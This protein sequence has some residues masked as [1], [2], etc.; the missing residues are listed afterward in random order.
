ME[1]RSSHHLRSTPT[2]CHFATQQ[3]QQQLLLCKHCMHFIDSLLKWC[4]AGALDAAADRIQ[5]RHLSITQTPAQR[6]RHLRH[7]PRVFGARDRQRT[8]GDH[9]VQR[10]L[11]G[12]GVEG[13][14]TLNNADEPA[15]PA[16]TWA[17]DCLTQRCLTPCQ[18]APATVLEQP[19]PIAR[20]GLQ[21]HAPRSPG[22]PHLCGRL[23]ASLLPDL[24][25]QI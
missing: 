8:L 12:E 13:K 2:T 3:G 14:G 24:P 23:A 9:P 10:H 25:Q 15:L 16:G 19:S 7:L 1:H 21:A 22:S 20:P 5:L 4:A 6:A 17:L 11:G 18:Q